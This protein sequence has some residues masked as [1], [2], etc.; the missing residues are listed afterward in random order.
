MTPHK[1]G[2]SWRMVGYGPARPGPARRRCGDSGRGGVAPGPGRDFQ[3]KSR[4][5][6]GLAG[7]DEANRLHHGPQG[8]ASPTLR[9]AQL[10]S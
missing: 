3:G 8:E 1:S 4:A 6:P 7:H 9:E 10:Q 2:W 5:C